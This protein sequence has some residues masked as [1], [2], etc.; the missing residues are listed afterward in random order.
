MLYKLS[1]Q[2]SWLG[3]FLCKISGS[4][5]YAC[6]LQNYMKVI[7]LGYLLVTYQV[8]VAPLLQFQLTIQSFL[9]LTCFTYN[10]KF[11]NFKVY[12]QSYCSSLWNALSRTNNSSMLCNEFLYETCMQFKL[13]VW[14]HIM[15]S[16]P[17]LLALIYIW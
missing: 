2:V 11:Q 4:D 12:E 9:S 17:N 6:I 16:I 15:T 3:N 5:I 10:A 1:H 7:W 8:G 14:I 13:L